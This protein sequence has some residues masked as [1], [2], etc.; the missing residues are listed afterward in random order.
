ME[1][2]TTCNGGGLPTALFRH[3]SF[4][5][6]Q[7]NSFLALSFF[8]LFITLTGINSKEFDLDLFG[9]W[10]NWGREKKNRQIWMLCFYLIWFG[11]HRNKKLKHTTLKKYKEKKENRCYRLNRGNSFFCYPIEDLSF[12]FDIFCLFDEFYMLCYGWL[13]FPHRFRRGKGNS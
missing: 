10:E 11:F 1:R 2:S 3:F 6:S 12:W 5:Q 9:N 13:C 7:R 8:S 4:L